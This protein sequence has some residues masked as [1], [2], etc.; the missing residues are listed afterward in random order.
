M[1]GQAS[2]LHF[3]GQERGTVNFDNLQ[4]TRRQMQQARRS[5]ERLRIGLSVDVVFDL[6]PRRLERLGEL[7]ADE[8]ERLA[9]KL[10]HV[11]GSV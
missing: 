7:T 6:T 11:V 5:H 2:L 4:R 3:L 8:F 10:L 1:G 9:G